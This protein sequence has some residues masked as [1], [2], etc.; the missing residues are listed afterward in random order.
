MA[1]RRGGPA[2]E[3][4]RVCGDD[5]L[6]VSGNRLIE[7]RPPRVRGR[8]LLTRR[9]VS[10][11]R[12]TPA[13]AGTTTRNRSCFPMTMEDPRVCGDDGF[14]ATAGT[15][16]RGRPPRVRGRRCRTRSPAGRSRKTPACAGTTGWS[17]SPPR[18]TPEDP[19]VCGDDVQRQVAHRRLGG[20]PPRVRG[21]PHDTAADD[22]SEGKTPACAGTT[23]WA[24]MDYLTP[25]GRPPR[26]R[27]RRR[28]LRRRVRGRGKTPACAGTT[29]VGHL[30]CV[31]HGEDPRVCGD[32]GPTRTG[33]C[34]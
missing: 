10:S 3:D 14:T 6:R 11:G 29:G 20:R 7:G 30:V 28:G 33:A 8:P 4:P 26:V 24:Q 25:Q 1:T 27:G 5:E 32:D 17:R 18:T 12:K 9:L 13:C 2:E 31:D 23:F 19:R 21:R 16:A 15:P 22:P 34:T